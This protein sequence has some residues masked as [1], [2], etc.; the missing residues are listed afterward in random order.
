MGRP[1]ATQPTTAELRL[2]NLFWVHG[3]MTVR[4][5]STILFK[6][7]GRKPPSYMSTAT[8]VRILVT[9]KLVEI[10]DVRRPQR[11]RAIVTREQTV[12]GVFNGLVDDMFNNNR[13]AFLLAIVDGL[14]DGDAK[15]AIS[16]FTRL[17]KIPRITG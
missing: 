15:A 9:K 13:E 4:D 7:R 1:A 16:E 10:T 2:L 12:K 14:F 5:I 11:F 8:I 17:S 6:T 3:T